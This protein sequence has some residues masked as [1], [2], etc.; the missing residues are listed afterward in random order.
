MEN[1]LKPI[2][3]DGKIVANI[4]KVEEIRNYVL[5]QLQQVNLDGL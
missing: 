2:I 4:P 5:K 1:F 3:K